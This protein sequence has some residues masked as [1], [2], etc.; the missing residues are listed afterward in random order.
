MPSSS[1]G[2]K[3]RRPVSPLTE[4]EQQQEEEEEEEE[5]SLQSDDVSSCLA[6][7]PIFNSKT[8]KG[9]ITGSIKSRHTI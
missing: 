8:A 1:R 5:D 3:R 2:I 9:E 7:H 6:R 4:N